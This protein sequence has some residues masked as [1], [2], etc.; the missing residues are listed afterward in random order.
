RVRTDKCIERSKIQADFLA[1]G[2]Q[3]EVPCFSSA[4]LR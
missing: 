3:A 1:R 2:S 4:F